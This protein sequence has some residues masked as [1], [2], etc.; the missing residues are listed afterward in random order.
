LRHRLYG[1]GQHRAAFIN[2]C[3]RKS[4]GARCEADFSDTQIDQLTN[5]YVRA[6]EEAEAIE[7][8]QGAYPS[9]RMHKLRL[10]GLAQHD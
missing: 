6:R 8:P 9:G 2:E 10:I 3:R 1:I 4:W 5:E 7:T